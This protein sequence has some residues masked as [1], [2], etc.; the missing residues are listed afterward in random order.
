MKNPSTVR[1]K[2]LSF[3]QVNELLPDLLAIPD[4]VKIIFTNISGTNIYFPSVVFGMD[5]DSL[6]WKANLAISAF[7]HHQRRHH[8]FVPS[9][10]DTSA[11]LFDAVHDVA[12]LRREWNG[13][14]MSGLNYRQHELLYTLYAFEAC[15]YINQSIIVLNADLGW[16][17]EFDPF[18]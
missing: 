7:N 14:A 8:K 18:L 15:P 17:Y 1:R 3:C 10:F 2:L 11:A 12:M 9:W 4:S 6:S 16:H 5:E 13:P